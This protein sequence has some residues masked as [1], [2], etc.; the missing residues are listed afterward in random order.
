MQLEKYIF[1][2]GWENMDLLMIGN[3][4][5]YLQIKYFLVIK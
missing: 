5:K 1:Y 3:H 2:M 4:Y